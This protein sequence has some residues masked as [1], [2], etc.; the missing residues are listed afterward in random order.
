MYMYYIIYYNNINFVSHVHS[1]VLMKKK[2]YRY[3]QS[4]TAMYQTDIL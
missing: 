4:T 3:R 2:K 1:D